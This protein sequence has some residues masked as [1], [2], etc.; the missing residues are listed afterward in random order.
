MISY[1]TLVGLITAT[2]TTLASLPQLIKV[3]KTKQT[4][5][6]SF[7]MYLMITT[8]VLLWFI[9]GL[10]IKDIP[11]IYANGVT[12]FLVYPI[13]FFKIKNDILKK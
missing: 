7:Y 13:F 11:I 1:I 2:L 12:L 9:Y 8:G 5:D 10:L 6:I 4:K 3:I